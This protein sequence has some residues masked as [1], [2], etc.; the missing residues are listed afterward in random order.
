MHPNAE[1]ARELERCVSTSHADLS[2]SGLR[3]QLIVQSGDGFTLTPKGKDF[4]AKWS[5][6]FKPKPAPI[7]V[8]TTPAPVR[9]DVAPQHVRPAY[10]SNTRRDGAL[11]NGD[12]CY[13]RHTAHREPRP[14]NVDYDSRRLGT[15][16]STQAPAVSDQ[17]NQRQFGRAP[18][19]QQR[20]TPDNSRQHGQ[21]EQFR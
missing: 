14:M 11:P 9:Q 17:G 8:V 12:R 5:K 21:R 7:A 3:K 20:R 4:V 13:E 6:D 1:L 19:F 15:P 16:Q 10:S 2:H 18:Q